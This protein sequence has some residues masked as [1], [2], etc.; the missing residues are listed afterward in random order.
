MSQ[1]SHPI[2]AKGNLARIKSACPPTAPAFLEHAAYGGYVA[3]RRNV[4]PTL[5]AAGSTRQATGGRG[6]LCLCLAVFVCV[7]VS[8][9]VCVCVG[10]CV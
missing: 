8:L 6:S 1:M 3:L 10:V 9:C 5:L 7:C 4:A 2:P